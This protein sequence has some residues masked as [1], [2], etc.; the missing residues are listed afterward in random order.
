MV[1][2]ERGFSKKQLLRFQKEYSVKLAGPPKHQLG[3]YCDPS[4]EQRALV[5]IK[6]S[7]KSRAKT[8]KGAIINW[9]VGGWDRGKVGR[10]GS[11]GGWG[12]TEGR[13]GGRDRGKVGRE[14]LTVLWG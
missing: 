3:E 10:E 12:G 11:G 6:T 5:V 7:N 14:G 4:I 2:L 8:T 9:K 1:V 13:W